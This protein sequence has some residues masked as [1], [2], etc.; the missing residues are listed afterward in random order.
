M[1]ISSSNPTKIQ[2]A[3]QRIKEEYPSA[4]IS[5]FACDLLTP[6]LEENIKALFE[7]VGKVDH[8]V[9]TAGNALA[10]NPL[11]AISYE[12]IIQ[13][14]T[15]RFIAPL[16]VAKIGSKWLNEGPGSSIV[17]TTGS[18]A[19]KPA[20]DWSVVTSYAAGL[21]GMTKALAVD[22]KPVRVNCVSPGP[23]DTEIWD[24]LDEAA[25]K[26]VYA[27]FGKMQLTGHIARG[28]LLLSV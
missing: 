19:E 20:S 28:K 24:V 1:T 13:A 18:T 16:L 6:D 11:S 2:N 15:V 3:I 5:G 26:K 12:S 21:H 8:I 27:E 14:G 17:L 22:L 23:V 10:L 9:F 7:K 4:E 25:R